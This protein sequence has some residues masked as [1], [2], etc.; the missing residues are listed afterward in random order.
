MLASLATA[1]PEL[2]DSQLQQLLAQAIF[3]ADVW[4]RLHGDS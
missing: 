4:G 2:D 1:W 3:V